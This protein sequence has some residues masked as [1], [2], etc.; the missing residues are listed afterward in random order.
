MGTKLI[1]SKAEL[2]ELLAKSK[3]LTYD[4]AQAMHVYIWKTYGQAN[5]MTGGYVDSQDMVAL[6]KKPTKATARTAYINQ[7]CY[8]FQEGPERDTKHRVEDT[9]DLL[10][11]LDRDPILK[12]I[13]R[14][15]VWGK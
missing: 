5:D 14:R 12:T 9:F 13:Y 4:Q 11:T 10:E 2:D 8:W 1:E 3:V 15:V 6:L 7:I